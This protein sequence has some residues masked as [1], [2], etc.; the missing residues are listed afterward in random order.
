MRVAEA[1]FHAVDADLDFE[2]GF[3][4]GSRVKP[5]DHVAVI[6]GN[7]RALLAAERTA[8]NF[9]QHLSGIATTTAEMVRLVSGSGVRI[10]DTRKTT[11]G[12]REL[13]KYAVALGG[14]VN[15]R[16]G[17]YDAYLVKNNHIALAGGVQAAVAA[18][19]GHAPGRS[20]E[21]EIRSLEELAVALDAGMDRILLDNMSPAEAAHAVETVAGRCEVEISGGITPDNIRAYAAAHPDYISLGYI[22][23]SAPALDMSMKVVA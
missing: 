23:H 16:H 14:G 6:G 19:R 15:H 18:A 17:L 13:E 21:V 4:D 11:P 5:G 22:T 12:W 2:T 20:V 9:L 1:V 10:L 8:L 7:A 3:S